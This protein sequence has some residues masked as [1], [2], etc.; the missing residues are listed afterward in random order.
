MT[1]ARTH[2]VHATK[3]LVFAN[4]KGLPRS[5]NSKATRHPSNHREGDYS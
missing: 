1:L 5:L 3:E 4:F 2:G